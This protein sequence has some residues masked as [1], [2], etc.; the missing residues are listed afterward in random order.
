LY[1]AEGFSKRI[2]GQ[3]LLVALIVPIVVGVVYVILWLIIG[4][5]DRSV[6]WTP[7]IPVAERNAVDTVAAA[8]GA[9]WGFGA[10]AVLE[11]SRVRFRTDGPIW[12]RALRFILGIAVGLAIWEG[13]D[14]V[15]PDDPLWLAIPLRI[16]RYLL[17][18]LWVAYYAPMVFVRLRLAAADPP[19]EISMKL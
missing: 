5:V 17:L 14:R 9:L 12:Q 15:F 18:L 13:L 10:G 16:I 8:V 3:K 2:L 7:F 1:F 19:Q 6:P 11:A 4:P